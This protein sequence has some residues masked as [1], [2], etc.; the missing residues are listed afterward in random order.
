MSLIH[1]IGQP[2]HIC[3]RQ[4]TAAVLFKTVAVTLSERSRAILSLPSCILQS[5][6]ANLRHSTVCPAALLQGLTTSLIF[7]LLLC[8]ARFKQASWCVEFEPVRE[9]RRAG[10]V[11]V[12]VRECRQLAS[13]T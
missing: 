11:Q 1:L 10:I 13:G 8:C 7:F 6:G 9:A 4:S 5:T 12:P 2:F 3:S